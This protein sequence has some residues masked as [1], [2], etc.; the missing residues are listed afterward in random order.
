[1]YCNP[2]FAVMYMDYNPTLMN[3]L[4]MINLRN[5]STVF[6]IKNSPYERYFIHT[7]ARSSYVNLCWAAWSI[8]D[9]YRSTAA[10]IL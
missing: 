7:Q 5:F 2:S 8:K 1:M 4:R 9:H 3:A 6:K 10:H